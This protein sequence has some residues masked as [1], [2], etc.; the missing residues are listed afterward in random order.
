MTSL[1]AEKFIVPV[2]VTHTS[3]SPPGFEEQ[4]Y[5]TVA[6]SFGQELNVLQKQ[7]V[8]TSKK[9]TK[10]VLTLQTKIKM[11]KETLKERRSKVREMHEKYVQAERKL[12][13]RTLASSGFPIS[14]S[15]IKSSQVKKRVGLPAGHVS[16]RKYFNKQLSMCR[17]QRNKLREENIKMKRKLKEASIQCT[18]VTEKCRQLG[19]LEN[20]NK[21]LLTQL[22]DAKKENKHL[23]ENESYLLNLLSD[24]APLNLFDDMENKFTNKTVET[25]MK[26]LDNG[27]A[28]A[29]VAP[30]IETV[31]SFCGREPDRLPSRQFVDNVNV[32]RLAVVQNQTADL[33]D[34]QNLTLYTDETSKYGSKYM[35]YATTT[36]DQKVHVLGMKQIPS[37]SAADTL[38]ALTDTLDEI[39]ETCG[40]PELG[41]KLVVNLKNTMSDRAATEKLFNSMLQEYRE[42]LL[43]SILVGFDNFTEEQQQNTIRMNHFFCGLHLLVSLAENFSS[44]VTKLEASVGPSC[45]CIGA[46]AHPQTKWFTKKSESPIIRFVRTTCKLL[47]R[48]AD[49]KNGCF[50]DFSSYLND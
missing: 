49:E 34:E 48:G 47:A 30:V 35:A 2:H 31:A 19:E 39:S 28:T 25:I 13:R 7:I 45:T 43:P 10:E 8:G 44:S 12:Q 18:A 4:T 9:H 16:R 3:R 27:V 50:A 40:M 41:R 17:A 22:G 29:S 1:R 21:E 33:V 42:K 20:E 5:K 24:N 38:E 36:A 26:L 46:A 6:A 15:N 11:Y 14:K 23:I 37:K 32:S